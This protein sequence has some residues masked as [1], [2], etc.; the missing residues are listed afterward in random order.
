MRVRSTSGS[1]PASSCISGETLGRDWEDRVAEYIDSERLRRRIKLGKTIMCTIDG[2]SGTYLTRTAVG[3][4]TEDDCT[5][6]VGEGVGGCKHT[7]ALRR[8]YK[9]RPRTFANLDGLFKRL[10]TKEKHELIR[11]MREMAIRAPT[12]LA[13]LG[14]K[15]F[16]DEPG[17]DE[18]SWMDETIR[19]EG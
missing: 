5:C 4:K 19:R 2:N 9:L 8:T 13:V 15:G 17:Y 6:P 1:N 10:E 3:K 18:D 11:L 16:D 12:A 14:V 7:E